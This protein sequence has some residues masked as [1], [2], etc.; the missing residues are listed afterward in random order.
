MKGRREKGKT[1][2]CISLKQTST[3]C[4]VWSNARKNA[5][6]IKNVLSVIL[7]DI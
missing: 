2:V 3:N 4:G 7:V 5:M 6:Y 1:V